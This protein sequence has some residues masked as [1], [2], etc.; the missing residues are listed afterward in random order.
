M[1][2]LRTHATLKVPLVFGMLVI[3]L[4]IAPC[5]L[6]EFFDLARISCPERMSLPFVFADSM[7]LLAAAREWT[8]SVGNRKVRGTCT[9]LGNLC[10]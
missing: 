4:D 1:V 6:R 2:E 3:H 10:R 9:H 8:N 5:T 7:H